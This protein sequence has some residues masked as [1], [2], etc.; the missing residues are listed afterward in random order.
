MGL[1]SGGIGLFSPGA[2]RTVDLRTPSPFDQVTGNP[3]QNAMSRGGNSLANLGGFIAVGTPPGIGTLD[4][5]GKRAWQIP[6]AVAGAGYGW[7]WGIWFNP[8]R[9]KSISGNVGPYDPYH[10]MEVRWLMCFD[11]PAGDINVARDCGVTISCGNNNANV[12]NTSTGGGNTRAGVQFGPVGIDRVRFRSVAVQNGGTAF[13]SGILNAVDFVPGFD[14]REW[15]V[16]AIRIVGATSQSDGVC[17]AL[18]NGIVVSSFSIGTAA[19]KFPATNAGIG[20]TFGY[21]GCWSN[22]SEGDIPDVYVSSGSLIMAPTESA[23]D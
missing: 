8:L 14:M 1:S 15:N 17:K 2:G 20:G 10:T 7:Q 3:S 18:I 6:S 5:K 11:R 13:D 4:R 22:F 23:L 12:F 21:K 9:D 16:W 19:A